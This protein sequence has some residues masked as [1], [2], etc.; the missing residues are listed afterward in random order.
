[1]T[2]YI[3]HKINRVQAVHSRVP[4]KWC[5]PRWKHRQHASIRL[6]SPLFTAAPANR[7]IFTQIFQLC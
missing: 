6:W 4:R 5:S 7:K 1:M 3:S 2:S